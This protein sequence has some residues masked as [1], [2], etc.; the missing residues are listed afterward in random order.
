MVYNSVFWLNSFPHHDRIH[1]TMNPRTIMTGQRLNYGKHYIRFSMYVQINEK[2]NNSME[3][4]TF[5]LIALR[6]SGNEQGGHYFL[7]Y[8]KES[9]KK[10]LD[11]TTHAQRCSKYCTQTSCSIQTNRRKGSQIWIEKS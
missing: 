1:L 2:N 9:N 10:Q 3:P 11:Q 5:R 4:R 6:P 8:R 7:R